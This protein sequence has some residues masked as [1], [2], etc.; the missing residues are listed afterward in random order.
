MY[1]V[2][3]IHD[4]ILNENLTRV[5][6]VFVS[7]LWEAV[8]V[9]TSAFYTNSVLLAKKIPLTLL[10][11]SWAEHSAI[12]NCDVLYVDYFLWRTYNE[13]V[14]RKKSQINPAWNYNSKQF[15]CLTGK[16]QKMHRIGLLHLLHTRN[17][18]KHAVTSL[19]V[20]PGNRYET[21]N[22]LPQLSD[23]EFDSFVTE[24]NHSPD[25][26]AITVQESDI[27]YSGIPYSVDLFANTKFRVISETY[28]TM[29]P[30]WITEKTWITILNRQPFLIAGDRG[31]CAKLSAMGFKTFDEYLI[32]P[33]DHIVDPQQRLEA[34]CDNISHWLDDGLPQDLVSNDVEHNYQQLVK[35]ANKNKTNIEDYL[36]RVNIVASIDDIISTLDDITNI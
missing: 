2:R 26:P 22:I 19:F 29:E 3:S 33:Y 24:Y 9:P 7:D 14:T 20:H 10:L 35:L 4:L 21:R 16:P 8:E 27:H 12:P 5:D 23:S 28:T 34:M 11:N 13:I 1:L 36:K 18:T 6:R 31:T 32:T 17:L 30:A 15:L 25:N